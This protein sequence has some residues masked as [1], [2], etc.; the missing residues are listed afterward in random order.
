MKTEAEAEAGA[1]AGSE[2]RVNNAHDK[3]LTRR[4]LIKN[5]AYVI[6]I[7]AAFKAR[8]SDRL[9]GLCQKNLTPAQTEGPFYPIEDQL[10]TDS[11]LTFIQ[12]S[13]GKAQGEIVY[14]KGIVQNESCQP[15]KGALVEI[16]QAC[17]SGRYNH[18]EDTNTAPID[19]HFQYWGKSTTNE[20][21][22]YFFKT[23]R[24]GN[25]PAAQN[26]IRPPHIH[27]KVRATGFNELTTQMYFNSEF[28][29]NNRDR[30]LMALSS[31]ERKKVIVEFIDRVGTFP[32]TMKAL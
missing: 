28:A 26:W 3:S 18:P 2:S 4:N 21:G 10:D 29:L 27:F 11:D 5:S 25:Y 7:L 30:I 6:G 13:A 32:I 15:V 8:A 19:P 12:G 14:V 20:K 9:I 1:G 22:E 23:I 17:A 24:P 16:W 31:S